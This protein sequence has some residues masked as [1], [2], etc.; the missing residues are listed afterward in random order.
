MAVWSSGGGLP[1][2]NRDDIV[3]GLDIDLDIDPF[4]DLLL[5]GRFDTESRTSTVT[6]AETSLS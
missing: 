2:I 1:D 3:N 4:V 6:A 5:A